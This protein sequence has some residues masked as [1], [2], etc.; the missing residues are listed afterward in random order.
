MAYTQT[1][2]PQSMHQQYRDV[3]TSG[4]P[5]HHPRQP[6]KQR[7]VAELSQCLF[8]F[9]IQLLP[10]AE[11]M[12]VKEDV[13]K[14]L[15]RLI[16]T[17]EPDSRLL[18]FGS[19]AN[20]FSLR[21][22][23]MD[24]C[25]LIDS[26]ERLA[27]SDLVTM[28]GDLL[29]RETKFHVK[30][31]PHARIPIV[32]L[33]LDPSP[34][35]PLGIACDIGF[36][37]RLALENTRLLMCYAMIDPTRVRTLV[38]FLKVWSKRRKI[39]SPYK[40]TLSSYGYVLLVIYFLVHV[41][42]PPIL[43]NLQ[44]MPPLR[45]IS[46]EDT[47]LG[48]HNTWFFDD[49]DLLRQRWRSENMETVAELLIDFFRYY[50]RDF[51]YNTGVAS[52]RAG[53]IKKEIKGW[54]ND[55]SA[56]RFND[57]RERNRF[58]IEDPFEIDFNVARCVTKD[59]LYTIRG[60]FM[61]A[62]R[63]LAARPERAILALAELCEERKDEDLVS[64]PAPR[65]SNLPPQTPYSVGSQSMRPKGGSDRFSPPTQFSEPSGRSPPVVIR[66]P[67]EH[68]AP[69]RG[70]WT[71]PPPPEA[72]SADHTLFENQLENGLSLATASTEAREREEA[73]NDSS[74]EVLTDED[75]SDATESDDVRSAHG[76]GLT[77]WSA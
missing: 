54:Q 10:T 19:T 56:G 11:E 5:T 39:N 23:D 64:A 70:K 41:K 33:T 66:S 9:V 53:L 12:A 2:S 67:P 61:R 24:L 77:A 74:S 3:H 75:R 18:S 4:S 50:S 22:S 27:A 43:P 69:K 38:L 6:S 17:I 57:A 28:L 59:G 49:I 35:L 34:G 72:P 20:G 52:I 37:N 40:G 55:L 8:D 71:S 60:E 25:C 62:S 58:C 65:L 63:V 45:P 21:N 51:L 73:H 32:K 26:D 76:D 46:K 29:E 47:H 68:M 7:F 14:L 31:L 42:N 1:L 13:R 30:P 44:Q 16:R 48:E 36:E 15:E